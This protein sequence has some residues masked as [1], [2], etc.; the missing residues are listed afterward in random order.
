VLEKRDDPSGVVDKV[1]DLAARRAPRKVVRPQV[2]DLSDL[3][4]G[5]RPDV[6][7][8]LRLA[9]QR[10]AGLCRAGP[11]GGIILVN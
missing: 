9:P 11:R 5:H 8:F 4:R 6:V 10:V 3:S 2:I 1:P 7:G